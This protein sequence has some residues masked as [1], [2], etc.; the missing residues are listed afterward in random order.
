[1]LLKERGLRCFIHIMA[2]CLLGITAAEESSI[3]TGATVEHDQTM[4][5]LAEW[6]A[7]ALIDGGFYTPITQA[8]DPTLGSNGA[9][10]IRLN[11]VAEIKTV[12]IQGLSSAD[13]SKSAKMGTMRIFSSKDF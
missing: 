2:A 10:I 13:S 1:M 3:L 8:S 5:N 7:S 11:D 12:F 9:F 6:D 4:I